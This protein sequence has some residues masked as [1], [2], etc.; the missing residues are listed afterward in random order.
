VLKRLGLVVLALTMVL[1]ACG[2]DDGGARS[3]DEQAL[4]D[5]MAERIAADETQPV[6]ESQAQCIAGGTMDALGFD[7]FAELGITAENV[8]TSM[9]AALGQLTEA[10]QGQMVDVLLGCV[11]FG[12]TM[13][14]EMKAQGLTDA[15][16]ACLSNALTEDMIRKLAIASMSGET[17]FNPLTDPEIGEAFLGIITQCMAG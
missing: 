16:A 3:A 5:A 7:R 6:T 14:E 1:A 17:D 8:E 10:E 4:V 11:D 2:D 13:V 15:Q 9:D 12:A